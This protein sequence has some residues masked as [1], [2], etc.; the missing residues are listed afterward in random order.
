MG[1]IDKE[2]LLS[3]IAL[4]SA[5]TSGY[6]L[7]KSNISKDKTKKH[8]EI[9]EAEGEFR[10]QLISENNRAKSDSERLVEENIDL[11]DQVYSLK[12]DIKNL[13]LSL[14]EKIDKCKVIENFLSHLTTP[15]WVRLIDKDGKF[16]CAYV[17]FSFCNYF[18][19]SREFCIGQEN[20]LIRFWV[21]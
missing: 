15:A 10:D 9:L 6:M 18:D 21:I 7:Y 19:V 5:V 11:K 4:I 16:R 1:I 3:I 12:I 14:S 2:V 20:H 8:L 17:N 13:E